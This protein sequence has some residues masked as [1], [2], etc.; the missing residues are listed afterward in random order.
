[1]MLD[2]VCWDVVCGCNP[3]GPG[4]VHCFGPSLVDGIPS[5]GYHWTGI[6]ENRF[7]TG[8]LDRPSARVLVNWY[9]G[10]LFLRPDVAC[11]VFREMRRHPQHSYRL[12]TRRPLAMIDVVR[13]V[14]NKVEGLDIGFGV[15]CETQGTFNERVSVLMQSEFRREEWKT[16]I[17]V[18]PML[19]PIR[20]RP[21][22]W[23]PRSGH[24]CVV[25]VSGEYGPKARRYDHA[26]FRSLQRECGI[27]GIE[28]VYKSCSGV[29]E[30]VQP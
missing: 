8:I 27:Y 24:P 25:A 23:K 15:S 19:G 10:D 9:K 3:V 21:Y 26:W 16:Y 11:R 4:C 20:L 22:S 12:L 17:F 6:I 13:Q 7:E 18:K 29:R 30:T 28:C 14:G 2:T 1:M 5:D